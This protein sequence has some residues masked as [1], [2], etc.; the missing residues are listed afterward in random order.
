MQEILSSSFGEGVPIV[1][2]VTSDGVT[3]RYLVNERNARPGGTLSGPTMM[4]LADT[5]AWV[6]IMSRVGPE[7]LAVTTS[8]TINF[9]RKP[10]ISDLV[11]EAT[12]DKLGRKLGVVSVRLYSSDTRDL[13]ATSSVTYARPS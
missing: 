5:A 1:D 7:L 8:L 13:V 12:L 2:E 9:L 3:V 6:A 11:A 4:M 10:S